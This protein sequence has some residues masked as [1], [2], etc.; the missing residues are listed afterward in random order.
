MLGFLDKPY[1]YLRIYEVDIKPYISIIHSLLISSLLRLWS[2][3][4]PYFHIVGGDKTFISSL[5]G[6]LA[7]LL[8]KLT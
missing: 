3:K 4:T 7:G 6:S 1:I 5:L 2:W 8:I